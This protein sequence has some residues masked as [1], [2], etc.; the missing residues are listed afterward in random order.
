MADGG[1]LAYGRHLLADIADTSADVLNDG[2]ALARALTEAALAEGTTVLGT[3]RHAF[4]PTG[5]TV[6][7][8]LAESHV[9]LHTYPDEG[10]AFFDAFTCGERCEPINIFR[11]FAL[12]SAL[13]TYRIIHCER[14]EAG[15]R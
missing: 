6:L 7:L 12:T 1:H 5:V 9:S 13:G 8:L 2:E 15:K 11:R 14:G 4:E 10:R 3:I